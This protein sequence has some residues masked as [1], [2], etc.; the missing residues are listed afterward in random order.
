MSII[1]ENYDKLYPLLSYLGDMVVLAEAWKKTHT[2][3]RKHNWYADPLELD[4]STINLEQKIIEWSKEIMNW[5]YEPGEMRLVLAPKNSK[6]TFKPDINQLRIDLWSPRLLEEKKKDDSTSETELPEENEE[7]SLTGVESTQPLRPLA[8]LSIK[9]QTIASA[10]MMCLAD[11]IETAQGPSDESN[12]NTAQK[13]QIFSYGNRLQ[14]T[15]TSPPNNRKLASFSWGSSHCYRQYYTDYQTFLKRPRSQAQYYASIA[16]PT[17][18]LFILSF[19]LKGFYNH[20]D[21]KALI[22]QLRHYVSE[23]YINS[24][25]EVSFPVEGDDT[26]TLHSIDE[27]LESTTG[28]WETV[29]TV[30]SWK[31][32]ERDALVA[33]KTVNLSAPNGLPQ[34]LVASGFLANAYLIGFDRMIGQEINRENSKESFIIRDYCRYVDD[35]RL[36][37]EVIGEKKVNKVKDIFEKWID[38][39]LKEHQKRIGVSTEDATLTINKDKTKVLPFHQLAPGYHLSA[40]MNQ[41]QQSI[42]G[43][44]DQDTIQQTIGTLDGLFHLTEYHESDERGKTRNSLE[45]SR[46]TATHVDVRDDTLK[47][48]A[49]TRVVHSLRMKRTMTDLEELIANSD[50][51]YGN[52][53][54]GQLLDHEF[55]SIARKLIASW[56][57]NPSLTLLLRCAFD[58]YPDASLLEVVIEALETKLFAPDISTIECTR[59]IKVAEYVAADLFQAAATTIGYK[60]ERI[61]PESADISCFR[62]ALGEFATKLLKH[63]SSNPWY[64]KQQAILFLSTIGIFSYT[65]NAKNSEIKILKHHKMLKEVGQFKLNAT[66]ENLTEVVTVSLVAQQVHPSPVRFSSWFISLLND[67]NLD[68]SKRKEA[69]YKLFYNRPDLMDHIL[70]STRIRSATWRNVIP[71][72]IRQAQKISN[73]GEIKLTNNSD[74]SLLRITKGNRNPF[75]QENALLM[76]ARTILK[77]K[78]AHALL[79][80]TLSINSITVKCKDWNSIQNPGKIKEE[81]FLEVAIGGD[82]STSELYYIPSWVKKEFS[83]MY[84]L[85]QILRSCITGEYD[86][87]AQTYLM[88]DQLHSYRGL[89]STWYTRRLGMNNHVKGLLG[90]PSPLSPWVT[91]LLFRLLQWPGVRTIDGHIPDIDSI[92][93]IGDLLFIIEKRIDAQRQIYGN[94][95]DTPFYIIPSFT[96]AKPENRNLRVAIVQPLL[97]GNDDFCVQDPLHWTPSFRARHRNH[98]A[99]MCNLVNSHIKAKHS[100]S[101]TVSRE[102]SKKQD[103]DLIVFPEL[104]IHP[105]D[106][107]LL[108]GLS[109]ATGA[110]IYAGMTFIQS[111]Q[112]NEVRNQALWLLR[113][114]RLTGREFTLVYQGKQHMTKSEQDLNVQGY[115]PYQVI[116]EFGNEEI[117]RTRLA[118]AICYDATDLSLVADL[119][120]ISDVFVIAAMNQDVNTFD[121]MVGALHYHM[122]Q[123]VILANSGEFGGSTVQAPLTKHAR[124]IAHVHG[125]NQVAVSMFEIDASIF[126]SVNQPPTPP[127]RKTPP[128]GYRGRV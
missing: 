6:W 13:N 95:S 65:I 64:V 26:G 120:D 15:W 128:A 3:I 1:K 66:N 39:K 52:V 124:Q 23:Y 69:L 109:D 30:F 54:A 93:N 27:F 71:P 98:I 38:K 77:D 11:A 80:S 46:V 119:R 83:W 50:D 72:E 78:E 70:K 105:D 35:I 94:L 12:F 21:R 59:E 19:D 60:N 17:S 87:T 116:V 40:V 88:R 111:A 92:R 25:S 67:Q 73:S 79:T 82:I 45:L 51:G 10:L 33:E 5:T 57:E 43:T 31:W 123:P 37:V 121:N 63:R 117:G 2:Y 58:L 118:G 103:M 18:D 127:Q 53:K 32:N 28:F 9:D 34:G 61:Y 84:N 91:E 36:V 86:F 102:V 106:L 29:E 62:D 96:R 49:A 42:S 74:L 75:K 107:D 85:G 44:P 7:T 122:Y 47:R 81:K 97:P 68:D 99:S 125:N 16:P 108:R 8:H 114:E 4:C 48:F 89:R 110:N 90:E 41:I 76:L 104:T 115:R 112:T 24:S 22:D 14:C 56:A 101:M 113:T 126:K 100:A 55:E 20:I